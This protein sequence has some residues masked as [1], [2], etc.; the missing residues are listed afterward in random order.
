[1]CCWI[2]NCKK[3]VETH[4]LLS[5]TVCTH[6]FFALLLHDMQDWYCLIELLLIKAGIMSQYSL[7]QWSADIIPAVQINFLICFRL[8][9]SDLGVWLTEYAF[10]YID[11]QPVNIL[12]TLTFR[13]QIILTVLT[14]G[15]LL[16]NAR[17]C[18][19]Y[20]ARLW[21][22][23]D[24][25]NE[26]ENISNDCSLCVFSEQAGSPTLHHNIHTNYRQFPPSPSQL[27]LLVSWWDYI[28]KSCRYTTYS[29]H[30][31]LPDTNHPAARQSL[32]L[33]RWVLDKLMIWWPNNSF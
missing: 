15:Q 13:Q 20:D 32:P 4:N 11:T 17:W 19:E 3:G 12:N 23:W 1:M 9:Q 18:Y 10:G 6:L 26:S 30:S 29:H 14:F 31:Q 24:E 22:I 16:L 27:F 33:M 2:V 21:I 28:F 25:F 7:D 5:S 8:D